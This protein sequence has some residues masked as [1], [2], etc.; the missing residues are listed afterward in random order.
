MRS[1]AL[2]LL[3][4]SSVVDAA[5]VDLV[6][7][8]VFA[9]AGGGPFFAALA[10]GLFRKA[11]IDSAD[12]ASRSIEPSS[13]AMCC[14]TPLSATIAKR[15]ERMPALSLS[16]KRVRAE[17]VRSAVQRAKTRS[18]ARYWMKAFFSFLSR[19]SA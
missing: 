9:F 18:R 1:A 16:A 4:S 15:C 5:A 3:S 14:T 7:V 19:L 8:D 17:S 12:V 10:A 13:M 2:A 6:A 11:R